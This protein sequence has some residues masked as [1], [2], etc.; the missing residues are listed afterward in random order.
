VAGAR[1]M[2]EGV[3]ALAAAHREGRRG[4]EETVEELI[5]ALGESAGAP[6]WLH[7]ESPDRLRA[8]AR[9]LAGGRR[10]LPLLGVPFAVKD[11]IDVA[12]LTTSAACP[13]YS[14]RPERTAFV[15]DRLLAAGA[16]L[17]GKTNMDQFA[18]GLV[19]TRSPHGACSSAFSA[20]HV[21][22]G[23]SSGSAVAV[24]RGLVAFS[25][26][27]DTA[28][29]GRVPAAFN[30]IVGLKPTRGLVSN[31]GVVPAC[32]TL[33]CV[34]I[35]AAEVDDAAAVLAA[36]AAYDPAD[37][38][39]RRRPRGGAPDLARGRPSVLGVP[40]PA[41]LQFFGD[42]HAAE[43]W[44]RARARAERLA[45]RIVEVDLA[46]FAEAATLLYN[47]PWLAERYA[48]L[49]EFLERDDVD[50][51]PVVRGIILAGAEPSAA[52]AFAGQY[53]IAEL[54]RH[55]EG[56]FA[57]I[58]ALITPTAPTFP[59]HAEVAAEPVAANAR[60]GT[61]TNFVNL[62]DLAAVAVPAGRRDDGLPFGVTLVGPAFSDEALVRL[63]RA[64]AG[65]RA[66]E[67]DLVVAGAHLSGMPR[68]GE[69]LDLGARLVRATR[70]APS[71]RFFDLADG[72]GR[73]GLMRAE[74]GEAGGAVEV[75]VWRL[76]ER[77]FGELV[78]RVAPP[79]VIGSVEL[80]NGTKS[81][82]FLCE[83]H[84]L[85]HAREIT[86]YGGW[87]AYSTAAVATP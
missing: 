87:K 3:R 68:N 42:E 67:I 49:G 25:L 66:V 39:S 15:V 32:R 50:P 58:D 47:G 34:S 77:A 26:G 28:G 71:Y 75:E 85:A 63:A 14:Y 55:A 41:S 56:L 83:A 69:L 48:V 33:D 18:T 74:D 6:V 76:D 60:L 73:P 13:D 61:Y 37:A 1:G 17:A 12:G 79:L 21:S 45:D 40:A 52:D 20:D 59:T 5:A 27:T 80:E 22:G 51:D 23:S 53:R 4:V 44:S 30:E 19:G 78:A 43:A 38:F 70:S 9:E 16:V 72:T 82:G 81:K 86:G 8:R 11:N 29:S 35:F 24:A 84:A 62:L 7:V 65:A 54:R 46:P 10:D 2:T 57:E 31:A 64:W 36:C